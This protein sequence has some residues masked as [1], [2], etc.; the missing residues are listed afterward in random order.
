[1]SPAL[2]TVSFTYMGSEADCVWGIAV[3]RA[4][5]RRRGKTH[6]AGVWRAAL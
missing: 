1:M 6:S 5:M 4:S 2:V 3:Q